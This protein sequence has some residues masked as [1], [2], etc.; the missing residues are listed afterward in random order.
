MGSRGGGTKRGP[1]R[2]TV[3]TIK[4]PRTSRTYDSP[5]PVPPSPPILC[6]PLPG[7]RSSSA[8]SPQ[9]GPYN[10]NAYDESEHQKYQY[11]SPPAPPTP[12]PAV[13]AIPPIAAHLP[14][15]HPPQ[16]SWASGPPPASTDSETSCGSLRIEASVPVGRGQGQCCFWDESK[17]HGYILDHGTNSTVFVHANSLL[18][19]GVS[20]LH[21]GQEV[22]FEYRKSDKGLEAVNITASSS[23]VG[24]RRRGKIVNWSSQKGFGFV[25][26]DHPEQ[27]GGKQILIHKKKIRGTDGTALSLGSPVSTS[28]DLGL[29]QVSSHVIALPVA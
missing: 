1:G 14:P 11:S 9:L 6:L 5:E 13:Y 29:F 20:K 16:S 18:S 21:K 4:R 24:L 28:F 10:D 22:E 3:V 27:F 12:T 2:T 19:S 17:I 8:Q 26:D 7:D 23:V 25:Q 15:A